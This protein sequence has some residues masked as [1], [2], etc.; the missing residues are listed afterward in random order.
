MRRIFEANLVASALVL[1][2]A[3]TLFVL[4]GNDAHAAGRTQKVS[5]DLMVPPRYPEVAR[6]ASVMVFDLAPLDDTDPTVGAAFADTLR[7]RLQDARVNEEPVFLL[8]AT[9]GGAVFDAQSAV[10]V[11]ISQGADAVYFGTV[12]GGNLPPEAYVE[13][14]TECL[15]ESDSALGIKLPKLGKCKNSRDVMVPC[16]RQ[17]ASFDVTLRVADVETREMLYEKLITRTKTESFCEGDTGDL[18]DFLAAMDTGNFDDLETTANAM[19]VALVQ[20]I[21]EEIADEV[22]D[23][24]VPRTE[25]GDVL[26]KRYARNEGEPAPSGKA[27]KDAEKATAKRFD[28]AI[29]WAQRGRWDRACGDWSAMLEEMP[30]NVALLYNLGICAEARGDMERAVIMF[31]QASDMLLEPDDVVLDALDRAELALEA[32]M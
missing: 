6:R 13:K 22:R 18:N 7:Q 26:L 23:D 31:T 32:L 1:T 2:A 10:S 9:S 27:A 17:T 5:V 24:V 28:A 19:E 8:Q 29:K 12:K 16:R 30:E 15:D 20:H 14:R 21:R 4:P 3:S 25:P 11:A